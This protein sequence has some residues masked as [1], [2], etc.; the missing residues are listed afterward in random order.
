MPLLEFDKVSKRYEMRRRG[1]MSAVAHSEDRLNGADIAGRGIQALID[2]SLSISPGDSL[3]II[4]ES[5]SGKTTLASLATGLLRPTSG[6]ILIDG[7]ELPG[8]GRQ[9]RRNAR[10]I[11][12]I[13]QDGRGSVDP[14]M[15]VCSIIR[16]PLRVHSLQGMN[17]REQVTSLLHEVGLSSN[18]AER[19]PDEL[20]GGELQRVVIARALALSPGLLICD[21]LAASLD[22]H[23]KLQ[24]VD[25]LLKLQSEKNLALIVIAHDLSL[26]SRMTR[27]LIVM[28]R[29]EI[30]ERGHTGTLIER[31]SHP[32]TQSLI[33][34]DPSS[35]RSLLA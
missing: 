5:G 30:V 10:I 13:W 7:T 31:P 8:D 35:A 26:I 24:V 32:Y 6:R 15:K 33:S 27:E 19:Y 22:M 29:G 18:L 17:V 20:S 21:E 28:N 25:L 23:A 14:R 2:I 16:E 34:C 1:R 4:G 9:R 3:G 11:Q 12:L